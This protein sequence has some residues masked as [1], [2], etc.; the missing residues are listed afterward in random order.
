MIARQSCNPRPPELC[1]D[2]K[3]NFAITFV[4]LD[5]WVPSFMDYN[6]YLNYQHNYPNYE[7]FWG[8]FLWSF[9]DNKYHPKEVLKKV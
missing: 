6:Y 2:P 9:W 7:L 8:I 5:Y 1:E 4:I 3:N